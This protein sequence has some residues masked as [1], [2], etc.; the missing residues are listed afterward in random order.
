MTNNELINE[1]IIK[2]LTNW[3]NKEL[4]PYVKPIL[5]QPLTEKITRN[6]SKISNEIIDDITSKIP[7][8]KTSNI[9]ISL[10]TNI[11]TISLNIQINQ[12][13]TLKQKKII[14]A[15]LKLYNHI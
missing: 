10:I 13:L 4:N 11:N 5:Y 12:K 9:T 7:D 2:G 15:L 8:L 1:L 6:L 14:L 3:I